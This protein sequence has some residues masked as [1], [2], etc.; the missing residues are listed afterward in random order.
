ME[1]E[2]AAPPGARGGK[3]SERLCSREERKRRKTSGVLG[4]GASGQQRLPE[5]SSAPCVSDGIY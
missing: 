5:G 1:G 4:E 3:R 2:L